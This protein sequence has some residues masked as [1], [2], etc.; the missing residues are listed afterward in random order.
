V[1]INLTFNEKFGRKIR[2]DDPEHIGVPTQN[3]IEQ[4]LQEGRTA[5]AL[6]LIDYLSVEFKILKDSVLGGWLSDLV[7]FLLQKRGCED[8]QPVLRVPVTTTW[9]A[10][11]NTGVDLQ[12][13]VIVAVKEGRNEE[14]V[15]LLESI[16]RIFKLVNDLV[17][18][19]VQD[20][21]TYIAE[22]YGE[23]EVAKAQRVSYDRIW[24]HRYAKWEQLT[25]EEQLALS[26]EGMRAHF[27][28]PTR[29]GEFTVVEEEDRYVMFFDPCGTGGVMRRG[30][31]ETGEGPWETSGLS[32]QAH[33][34]TWNRTE[35]PYYCTHCNLYL[36]HFAAMDY[37]HPIR[38]V[39]FDPDPDA[40]TRWFIYKSKDK[41]RE[42]HFRA[43]GLE[44]S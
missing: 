3:L 9:E 7:E 41:I 15:L 30:D 22:R 11:Y 5:D 16:R 26:A 20:I 17:V 13:Q 8:L 10:M 35:V 37:G 28:G 39:G 34:W 36:E 44:K 29:R 19:W 27:G 23:E 6:E 4:A 14:A 25:P 18:R 31:P 42:E 33:N 24:V 21:L 38:P 2:M 43:I 32:K 1:G 40:P 12:K